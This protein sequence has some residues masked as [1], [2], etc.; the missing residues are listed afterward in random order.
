MSIYI[1]AGICLYIASYAFYVTFSHG[2]GHKAEYLQL[3]RFI[4]CAIL[5]VLPTACSNITLS[6]PLIISSFI[7]GL[8]WI[9]TY[10]LLYFKTNHIRSNDFGYHL[11]IVF[12]L[13]VIGWLTSIKVIILYFN[14]LPTALLAIESTIELLL[15][16]IPLAQWGYYYLYDTCIDDNG[17][18]MIQETNYNEVIEY[19]SS[20]PKIFLYT[21]FAF[22][23][24]I[25]SLLIYTNINFLH[26]KSNISINNLI[27]IFLTFIFL[28]VYLW[29]KKKGVFIRTG[30]VEL[31]LDVKEYF[32]TTKLYVH[33]MNERVANLTVTPSKPLFPKPST[34]ILVIGESEARDYM[35]AFC[36]YPLNTTPWLRNK[37]NDD[38]FILF[39]H[40][41]STIPHTVSA[42]E[43][44]L[45]EFNQYND[46]Q[47][48]TSCSI[49][50][51]AHKAD[52]NTYWYSN[53]GHLG[54][55]DTPVTL[56]ANTSNVAKWTKQN[57]NQLQFDESLLEYL[58][59]IDPS[60]NNFVVIHLKGNHFNYINRYPQ[61]FAKFS[62]PD[63]Y[64]LIPNYLDSVAYTDYIL[65]QI[66]E[67]AQKNLNLQALLY[68]SD[69]GVTPDQ[70]RSPNFNG[71]AAVRIPMF[72]YFSEEYKSLY[73]QTFETLKNHSDY[74]W[75]NDL[76]YELICGILNITSN[77]YDESNSLASPKYK[78]TK[79]TLKTDLGKRYLKDDP[80]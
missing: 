28:T 55:A 78:F 46:K 64:D 47:F 79:E 8:S 37:K 50:D 51:I 75:T 21:S 32:E 49:I 53:Q 26:I 27:P 12:G 54:C 72:C 9:I 7:V 1:I 44:A 43:R 39:P 57:L 67:Y 58:P 31:Y 80:N 2:L 40:A 6:S 41:Y 36:D 52:Y 30:I 10:P 33:N 3:R 11:D 15:L 22:L 77:H 59:E 24:S 68:F 66:T 13:Y 45:T 5:A 73:P 71:F 29:K 14:F 63:K 42:L 16:L 23:V 56:V 60:T 4:P 61:S 70:R 35:S 62:K 20:L 18:M 17:M 74:Y 25:Y 48:Y 19:F 38:N 69:H 34:I 76:A 65:Q